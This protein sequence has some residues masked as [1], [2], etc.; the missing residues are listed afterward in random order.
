MF[1]SRASFLGFTISRDL[2]SVSARELWQR[3]LCHRDSYS[4]YRRDDSEGMFEE[5][6]NVYNTYDDDCD[7]G[8]F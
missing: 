3:V 8:I 4:K 5:V 7:T 6:E 1:L 2:L